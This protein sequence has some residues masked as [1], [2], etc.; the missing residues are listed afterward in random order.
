M[1][2]MLGGLLVMGGLGVCVGI[3]LA[4]ASKMFYVYVDPKIEA[5]DDALPGANCGG[6]GQPGC[7][8]NAAAIV[9]G[10]ASASSCVAGGP[11]V[12]EEIAAIMGVKLEAR[13]PDITSGIIAGRVAGR[14]FVGQG[15]RV[16][17]AVGCNLELTFDLPNLQPPPPLG[18]EIVLQI[19]AEMMTVIP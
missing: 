4:L 18:G 7:S 19:N 17:V 11:E 12:A 3:G 1:S 9:E 8:A 15:F 13:E 16:R 2:A 5:V 14:L 10:K 6:C